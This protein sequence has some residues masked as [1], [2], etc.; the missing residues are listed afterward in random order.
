[1]SDAVRRPIRTLMQLIASGGLTALITQLSEDVPPSYAP[2]I[3][4][5]FTVL[6]SFCQ[7]WMEDN[8]SQFPSI[9]KSSASPG[10]NPVTQDGK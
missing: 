6:I 5:A 8:V 7:N 2:Y 10:L 3:L 9:L 4:I 1:M